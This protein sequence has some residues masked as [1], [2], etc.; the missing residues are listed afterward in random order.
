MLSNN[1]VEE[2]LEPRVPRVVV[3]CRE[4]SSYLYDMCRCND[5]CLVLFAKKADITV[6][7]PEGFLLLP[8]FCYV[9][10]F[11]GEGNTQKSI[12]SLY[13]FVHCSLK[14]INIRDSRT[15]KKRYKHICTIII[16]VNIVM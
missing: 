6:C 3:C 10:M 8:S 1:F 7:G 13:F 5:F 11:L 14:L 12:N 15:I 16:R 9:L 2:G 4:P